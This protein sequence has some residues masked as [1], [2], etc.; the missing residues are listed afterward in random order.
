ML[1]ATAWAES[2]GRLDA[3]GDQGRSHGPFQEYDLGRGHGLTVA[4]RRDPVGATKRA[5]REF[6]KY[7]EQGY[8]GGELAY[9]AQ[10]PANREAYVS[11]I[12]SYLGKAR[13]ALGGGP[14]GP[15]DTPP[16]DLSGPNENAPGT[17]NYSE[18]IASSLVN[19]QQ[20]ESLLDA[21][22]KGVISTVGQPAI[23]PRKGYAVNPQGNGPATGEKGP[24]A[25]AKRYLGTPYSWGG[26]SPS[27]PTEGFGRGAGIVGFD[28]SSLVQMA[29]SKVGV[30]LPRT[31][32]EQIKVG[33]PIDTKNMAAWRPGDLLF[34]SRGHVQMYIGNGKVIEAPR[35]GGH[36]QIV[37]VRS[38]YIAVRRPR[39]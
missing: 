1:L 33:T 12:N 6:Q 22:V 32:Y 21:V 5:V 31:T 15:A 36:V 39:A 23:S 20:G 10:R 30:Q 13:Q 18:G 25:A 17:P 14:L 9:R 29:W 7:Y 11:K 27:G 8:R 24:V 26:G 38:R 37:P 19:R 2:G 34:P 28:C 35:T 16:P 3:V 4:Q